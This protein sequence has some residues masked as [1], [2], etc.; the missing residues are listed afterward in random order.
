M[1]YAELKSRIDRLSNMPDIRSLGDIQNLAVNVDDG[2]AEV[3][4][5]GDIGYNPYNDSAVTAHDLS[6][7]LS[8]S[9]EITE[10]VLHINS[11]GGD[12]FEGVTIYN[13]L[14]RHTATVRV[15]V[16][17]VAAS[18]ASIIAMAADDLTMATGSLIMI[19]DAWGIMIGNSSEARAFAAV[20]DKLDA[21][22]ASIYAEKSGMPVDDIRAMM[23]AETWMDAD[24]A[25]TN[26]FADRKSEQQA[27]NMHDLS[28][29]AKAPGMDTEDTEGVEDV[30]SDTEGVEDAED[31]ETG[32]T[33]NRLRLYELRQKLIE[34]I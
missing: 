26:G 15:T 13:M 23:D 18:A 14:K 25:I 5:Y 24:E 8:N 31:A 2:I 29:Y 19:H 1:K 9:G 7:A 34:A 12:A 27:Q 20:L 22:I 28:I 3:L 30:E 6:Q 21:Q 17:G 10:I 32:A 33:E 11:P 16:D 4:I